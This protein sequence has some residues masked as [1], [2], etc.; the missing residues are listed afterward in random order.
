MI[1]GVGAGICD[2]RRRHKQ[3]I[4][5]IIN[6]KQMMM[7]IMI[8]TKTP[9]A[10]EAVAVAAA[11]RSLGAGTIA[12]FVGLEVGVAVGLEVGVAVGLEVGV[13]GTITDWQVALIEPALRQILSLHWQNSLEQ[14]LQED[15]PYVREA[16][17]QVQRH[18]WADPEP[19]QIAVFVG[20]EVGVAV[21]AKVGLGVGLEVGQGAGAL[22]WVQSDSIPI[23]PGPGQQ[24]LPALQM[25]KE[26]S[27][28]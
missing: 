16:P 7:P 23:F 18:D 27:Q 12:V 9:A 26:P 8:A 21:G 22:H 17:L 15:T 3:T 13:A 2:D 4:P 14:A 20:L 5:T 25:V 6:A 11:V 24:K 19:A 1:A 10:I 28:T